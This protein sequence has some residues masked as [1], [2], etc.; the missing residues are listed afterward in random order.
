MEDDYT[1][2]A[3]STF[4]EALATAAEEWIN[5]VYPEIEAAFRGLDVGHV[6]TQLICDRLGAAVARFIRTAKIDAAPT[7]PVSDT[8]ARSE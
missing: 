6:E 2:S 1:R 3:D 7:Q 4:R 5:G 8:T